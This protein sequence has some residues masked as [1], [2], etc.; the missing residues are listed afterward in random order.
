VF[1]TRLK[2]VYAFGA[3]LCMEAGALVTMANHFLAGTLLVATGSVAWVFCIQRQRGTLLGRGELNC[4][5]RAARGEP[6][7]PFHGRR[8]DAIP[9]QR[10]SIRRVWLCWNPQF[11]GTVSIRAR[12]RRG[13]RSGC[14]R[15]NRVVAEAGTYKAHSSKGDV[16]QGPQ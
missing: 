9:G 10:I 11:S 4:L 2:Q 12:T 16:G 15:G 8:V 1:P 6:C 5:P 13:Y 3:V 7:D 14:L